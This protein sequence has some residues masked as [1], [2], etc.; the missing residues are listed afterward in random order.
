MENSNIESDSEDI[1]DIMGE[2]FW[3]ELDSLKTEIP[4]EKPKL[5]SVNDAPCNGLKEPTR[6]SQSS[7]QPIVRPVTPKSG[8]SLVSLQSR[9]FC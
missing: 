2:E 3:P 8:N 6:N 1:L 5:N 4:E 7:P 9:T